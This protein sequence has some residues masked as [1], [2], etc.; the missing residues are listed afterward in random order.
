M[1]TTNHLK[2]IN[3]FVVEKMGKWRR[4]FGTRTIMDLQTYQVRFDILLFNTTN[5]D[6][7]KRVHKK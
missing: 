2:I 6:F 3:E 1:R 5:K 4:Y 7:I